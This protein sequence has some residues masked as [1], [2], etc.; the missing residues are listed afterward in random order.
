MWGGARYTHSTGTIRQIFGSFL[1]GSLGEIFSDMD[2]LVLI[3]CGYP[4]MAP[5]AH[6]NFGSI[7]DTST[8]L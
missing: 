2:F 6:E 7:T 8:D 3:V 5:I 4:P 1:E